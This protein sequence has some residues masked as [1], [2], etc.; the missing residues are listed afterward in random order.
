MRKIHVATYYE[1]ATKVYLLVIARRR[2]ADS[3]PGLVGAGAVQEVWASA[4]STAL[5]PGQS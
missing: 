2:A 4:A 3:C 5:P 1:R